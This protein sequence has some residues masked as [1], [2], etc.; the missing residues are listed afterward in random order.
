MDDVN[1]TFI[2]AHWPFLVVSLALGIVGSVIK[3]A[4]LGKYRSRVFVGWRH[5]FH[6]T[7]PLH[8]MLTGAL[9]GMMPFMPCPEDICTEGAIKVL[10]Y[11]ASGMLSSY[12]Y[13]LV[14]HIAKV[15]LG[16]DFTE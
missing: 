7:L 10:Y 9:L 5:W 13:D 6:M 12:V 8:A 15:R 2:L 1:L 4:V 11:A 16:P 14:R 3:V